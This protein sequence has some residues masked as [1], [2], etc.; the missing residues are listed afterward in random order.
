M[1]HSF[2]FCP[3]LLL[4]IV[5]FHIFVHFTLPM[6]ISLVLIE[7]VEVAL[8]SLLLQRHSHV[9]PLPLLDDPIEIILTLEV[10]ESTQ[11]SRMNLF[12]LVFHLVYEV[13]VVNSVGT[14][15]SQRV[16]ETTTCSPHEIGIHLVRGCARGDILR[17]DSGKL[18]KVL[19]GVVFFVGAVGDLALDV[20]ARLDPFP[21]FSVPLE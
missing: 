12:T 1:I 19:V 2:R 20:I 10:H 16:T 13:F 11:A 7:H 14:R 8:G 3:G 6:H 21:P 15:H 17:V 18:A 5:I 9:S 4:L